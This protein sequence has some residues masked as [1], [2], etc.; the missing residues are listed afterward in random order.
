[1]SHA[2]DAITVTAA[3]ALSDRYGGSSADNSEKTADYS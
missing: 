1:M 3:C 2:F